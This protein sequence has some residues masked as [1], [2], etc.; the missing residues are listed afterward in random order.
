MLFTDRKRF[1]KYAMAILI[2]LPTWYCI[3]IL[4]TFS[5]EFGTKMNIQGIIDPGKSVMYSYAAISFGGVLSVS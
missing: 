5:K 2:G 1:K 3:G 4:I